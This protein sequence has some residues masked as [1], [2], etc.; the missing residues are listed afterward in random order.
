MVIKWTVMKNRKAYE[1][2][3]SII[4]DEPDIKMEEVKV[5]QVILNRYEKRAIR[6]DVWGKTVDNRQINMEMEN[7]MHD[8]VKK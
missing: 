3:L 6:L 5:E 4:L 1:N 8:D 2:T 7:N